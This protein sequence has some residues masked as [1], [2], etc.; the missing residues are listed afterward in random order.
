MALECAGLLTHL[1]YDTTVMV[2]SVLLRGFD[3]EMAQKIGE[4]MESHH[5]KF[6]R[7]TIP[8][9]IERLEDGRL[10]VIAEGPDH[11]EV[12]VCEF[13][14]GLSSLFSNGGTLVRLWGG[15]KVK[16]A[17][18]G[19]G[20]FASPRSFSRFERQG[21]VLAGGGRDEEMRGVSGDCRTSL[22]L[23]PPPLLLTLD[24]FQQ[25][26]Y[27]TVLMAIGRT[28]NTGK[29]RLERAGVVVDARLCFIMCLTGSTCALIGQERGRFQLM[30]MRPTYRIS[31]A[32]VMPSSGRPS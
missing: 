25:D 11:T 3:A 22:L 19:G 6:I 32:S 30:T 28:P 20:N 29:L 2:R 10:R 15:G 14:L 1:G 31:S 7:E 4:Y 13:L 21:R 26:T 27:D 18:D 12:V 8:K 16:Y 23:P 9:R 17:V 5:T 24:I